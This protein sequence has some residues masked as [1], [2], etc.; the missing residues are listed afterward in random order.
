MMFLFLLDCSFGLLVAVL[1]ASAAT[2]ALVV[3]F[4]LFVVVFAILAYGYSPFSC[5]LLSLSFN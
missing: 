3:T 2:T 4:F 5:F 1:V